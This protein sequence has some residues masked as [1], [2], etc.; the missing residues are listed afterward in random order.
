MTTVT[1]VA[2]VWLGTVDD[3]VVDEAS[4]DAAAL[5]VIS[6]VEL[7]IEIIAI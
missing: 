2:A 4:T 5:H 1:F 3:G 7:K 6:T